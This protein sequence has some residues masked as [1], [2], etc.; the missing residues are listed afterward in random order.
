[1]KYRRHQFLKVRISRLSEVTIGRMRQS[2]EGLK[3][4]TMIQKVLRVKIVPQ[5]LKEP[6]QFEIELGLDDSVRWAITVF[7]LFVL[8]ASDADPGTLPQVTRSRNPRLRQ[9]APYPLQ[10]R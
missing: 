8:S 6:G 2:S 9:L 10:F 3:L 4:K 5:T 1:M 7:S